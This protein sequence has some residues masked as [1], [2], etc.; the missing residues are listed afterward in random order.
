M[1]EDYSNFYE[2][3]FNLFKTE[4]LKQFAQQALK[5]FPPYFW[6]V[7]SS[8]GG[9]YHSGW[10]NCKPLGLA[11]HTKA[12][13]RVT[14]MLSDAYSLNPEEH[15]VALIAAFC[16]DSV[17]Y[18]FGGGK[19]TSKTHESEG[20]SFFKQVSRKLYQGDFPYFEETVEAI[21]YHQGR[22]CATEPPKK[23]PEEFSRIAQ[24]IHVADMVASRKEIT[25]TFIE[26]G[27]LLG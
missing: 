25:F 21:A 18:G 12:V 24:L 3:E 14:H 1:E 13:V 19:Y 9:K 17:K 2:E 22:W 16:H 27:S 11:K 6:Q 4:H 26:E 7:A 10:S 8:S 15:D 23:F 5:L 20:A